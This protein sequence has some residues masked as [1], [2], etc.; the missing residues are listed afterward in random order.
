LHTYNPLDFNKQGLEKKQNQRSVRVPIRTQAKIKIKQ[1]L[2][3]IFHDKD[4]VV[5]LLVGGEI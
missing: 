5:D 1:I 2:E 4:F 3:K